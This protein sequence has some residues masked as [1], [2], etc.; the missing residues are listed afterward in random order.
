M[1]TA[2][3]QD[4]ASETLSLQSAL[5]NLTIERV[6]RRALSGNASAVC[7]AAATDKCIKIK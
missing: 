4:V 6:I 2:I 5:L 7:Q 1:G 3:V